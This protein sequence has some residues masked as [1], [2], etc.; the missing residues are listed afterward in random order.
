MTKSSK[1]CRVAIKL[2]DLYVQLKC[3]A[4]DLQEISDD[5]DIKKRD[6]YFLGFIRQLEQIDHD[7][8]RLANKLAKED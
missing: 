7:L 1:N 2:V 4:S 6:A 5:F 3:I 8:V